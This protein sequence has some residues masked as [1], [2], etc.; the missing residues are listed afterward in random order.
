MPSNLSFEQAAAV[1]LGA[2]STLHAFV[3][4]RRQLKSGERVLLNGANGGIGVFAVQMARRIGAHVTAV[5]HPAHLD[6]VRRLG[7]D[8]VIDFEREDFV[9][10]GERFDMVFDIAPSRS[11]P[12]V[13]PVLAPGG[14]YATTVP[15]IA[16]FAHIAWTHLR[17]GRKASFIIAQPNGAN[18]T[19]ITEMIEQGQLEVVVDRVFPLAETAAAHAYFERGS[20]GG[21]IVLRVA[22]S[23]P[24]LY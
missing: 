11:Y 20:Y 14:R 12:Q 3:L 8:T 16:T 10:R 5:A 17:P 1:P 21:K 18:L 6:L 22:T 19:R 15:D 13:L 7:A 24:G 2:L 9:R 23:Q 4:G